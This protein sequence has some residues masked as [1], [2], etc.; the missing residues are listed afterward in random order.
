MTQFNY[1]ERLLDYQI[2]MCSGLLRYNVVSNVMLVMANQ[3]RAPF[4]A[5]NEPNNY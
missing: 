2:T 3:N 1:Q 5:D 4:I